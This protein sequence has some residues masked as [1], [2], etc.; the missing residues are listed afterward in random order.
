MRKQVYMIYDFLQSTSNSLAWLEESFLKGFEKADFT[1]AKEKLA[2]PI[3]EKLWDLESFFRHHLEND[4]K[5]FGKAAYLEAVQQVLD[6]IG[7]LTNES[8][9]EQ[10]Q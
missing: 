9:F 7:A 4:A 2:D 5:E 3:K 6:E 8:T 10:Y 1:V